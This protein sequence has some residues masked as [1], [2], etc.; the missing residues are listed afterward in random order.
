MKKPIVNKKKITKETYW[1]TCPVCKKQITGVSEKHLLSN[2][3]I[4]YLLNH[5][6][7][8]K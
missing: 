4:H 5:E 7:Q 2:Y 3:D 6:R 1:L 8:G